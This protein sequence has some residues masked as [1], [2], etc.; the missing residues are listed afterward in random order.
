[1]VTHRLQVR[2]RPVKVRRSETDVLPLSHPGQQG[3]SDGLPIDSRSQTVC[4]RDV[5]YKSLSAPAVITFISSTWRCDGGQS[6]LNFCC[7]VLVNLYLIVFWFIVLQNKCGF[8]WHINTQ[9]K[10]GVDMSTSKRDKSRDCTRRWRTL[11]N[12]THG[13]SDVR[14]PKLSGV[15]FE[16]IS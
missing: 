6:W 13:D 4:I 9:P 5:S 1:M 14:A 3:I 16:A 15:I 11:C 12:I 8:S 7:N 10:P 2:C